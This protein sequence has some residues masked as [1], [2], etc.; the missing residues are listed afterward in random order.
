MVEKGTRPSQQGTTAN[1]PSCVARHLSG[2]FHNVG[3]LLCPLE[4]EP[5]SRERVIPTEWQVRTVLGDCR[6]KVKN[7]L[8]SSATVSAL[9]ADQ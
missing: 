7:D 2:F 3:N 5:A 8:N 9:C 1:G 6:S 4:L